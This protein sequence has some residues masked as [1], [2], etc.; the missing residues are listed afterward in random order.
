MSQRQTTV[1]KRN[2]FIDLKLVGHTLKEV[3]EET[4]WSFDCVRFWWRRYR[5]GGR[6]VL[7]PPDERKQRG[8]PMSTFPGVVRFAFLRIKKEH[9]GWGA[10]VARPRMVKRLDIREDELCS[11]SLFSANQGLSVVILWRSFP[12]LQ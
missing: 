8:G 2:H 4:G 7:D 10:D 9:P 1:A 12:G 5:N 3:A 6:K 11:P